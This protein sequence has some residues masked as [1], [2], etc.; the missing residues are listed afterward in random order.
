MRWIRFSQ[1]GRTAYGILEGDRIAEVVGRS[2]RRL[3]AHRAQARPGRGQDRGAGRPAHLLLRR[4]QLRR[5]HPRGGGQAG[6]QGQPARAARRRLP[7]RQ[8]PDRPRRAGRDPARRH[9]G[10]V[11]GR[12]R[13]RHRQESQ[14]PERGRGALLRARLHH[15][16][17]RQRARL[18]EV[19]PHALARQ[20]HRHLQADGPVDRDARSISTRSRRA[21][22][23]TAR[24]P[25]AFAPTPCCSASPPTSPPSPATSPSTPATSSGWAPTAPRRT[26]KAGDVVEVEITGI[27]VLR[28]PFVAA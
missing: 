4:P 26:C 18:A 27:G 16:Q 17:R 11:R 2:L 24:R 14:G 22:A 12:A 3:R 20:E 21:C 9:Q 10:A 28:N 7:R 5:A 23:S 13:R 25:R 15:R 19:G 1:Q 8:R 6:H